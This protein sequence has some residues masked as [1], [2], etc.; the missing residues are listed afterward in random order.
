MIDWGLSAAI[1]CVVLFIM[2]G[3]TDSKVKKLAA[4][5]SELERNKNEENNDDGRNDGNDNT[6]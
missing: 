5:V 4:R 1:T 6:D 3:L 2:Q